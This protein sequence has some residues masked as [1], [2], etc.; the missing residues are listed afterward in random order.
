MKIY[1]KKGDTG[2]TS[3]YDG[4]KVTK[5]NIIVQAVGELDELN[6]EIWDYAGSTPWPH[7]DNTFYDGVEY[8]HNPN[9]SFKQG[10]CY[11][12]L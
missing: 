12:L 1:T 8:T 3:L 4:T 10:C 9:N 5:N 6:S 2:T 7:G 11:P